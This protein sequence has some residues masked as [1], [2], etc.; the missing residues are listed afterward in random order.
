MINTAVWPRSWKRRSF[1]NGTVCPRCTSIPVGSMPYLTRSGLPVLALCSSF[2]WRP[3][4]GSICSTP[5]R[6]IASCSSTGFMGLPSGVE[7]VLPDRLEGMTVVPDLGFTGPRRPPQGDHVEPHAHVPELSPLDE[8]QGGVR[9]P[10]LLLVVHRRGQF[11]ERL[12]LAR[13]DLDHHD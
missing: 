13:P 2:F 7:L 11:V 1:R 12:R 5:R 10:P 3:S 8:P 9:Q 6:R 4:R